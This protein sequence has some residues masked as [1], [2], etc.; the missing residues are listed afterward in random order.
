MFKFDHRYT[1]SSRSRQACCRHYVRATRFNFF[2]IA[3]LVY[4][5]SFTICL[6]QNSVSDRA[7]EWKSHALPTSEFKRLVDEENG[8]ILRVPASWEK[9][10]VLTPKG[11]EK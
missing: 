3:A 10:E 1:K 5:S 6:A 9:E 11:P 2:L 8:V 7:A 4:G